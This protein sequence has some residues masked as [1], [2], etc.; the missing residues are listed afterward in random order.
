MAYTVKWIRSNSGK[1]KLR[2]YLY[3]QYRDDGEQVRQYVSPATADRISLRMANKLK[4]QTG[5]NTKLRKHLNLLTRKRRV[6]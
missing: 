6:K 4:K 3:K 1:G 2:P 5:K